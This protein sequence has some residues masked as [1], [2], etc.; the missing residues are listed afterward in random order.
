[1]GDGGFVEV[2]SPGILYPQGFVCASAMNGKSGTYLIDPTDVA[3][4]TS[5][6]PPA[7]SGYVNAGGAPP[8]P[9]P[10]TFTAGSAVIFETTINGILGGGTSLVID[11]N[12][13]FGS[14]GNI[15]IGAPGTAA[16]I[17]YASAADLTFRA[18]GN[19]TIFESL[20]DNTLGAGGG[21]LAFEATA[22]T[23]TMIAGATEASISSLSGAVN[24]SCANLVMN[25]S[26][27]DFSVIA[28]GSVNNVNVLGDLILNGSPAGGG[29]S[30]INS[31]GPL[32]IT[33]GRNF[34]S[35][36]PAAGVGNI[37]ATTARPRSLSS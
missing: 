6:G 2:S 20:V 28:G 15:T 11:T 7:E 35:T 25:G 30:R 24:V 12:S 23:I 29:G 21:D 34:T 14:A 9:P 13:G 22:G 10:L 32:N 36:M 4:I 5:P 17:T 37:I 8:P 26:A 27:A 3:V 31:L 19:I 16:D 1:M 18:N 33:V